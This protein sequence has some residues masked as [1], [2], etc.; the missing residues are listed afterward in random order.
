MCGGHGGTNTIASVLQQATWQEP[1][2]EAGNDKKRRIRV[3]DEQGRG[4]DRESAEVVSG[5]GECGGL[6]SREG[7][8]GAAARTA[9]LVVLLC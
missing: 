8:R 1:L 6:Q 7:R 5:V 2:V 4:G 3:G 9:I